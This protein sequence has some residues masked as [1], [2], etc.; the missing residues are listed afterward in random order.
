M[1]YFICLKAS[2]QSDLMQHN[3][4]AAIFHL[5]QYSVCSSHQ[6]CWRA[7]AKHKNMRYARQHLV[8]SARL[9]RFGEM[10]LW[11]KSLVCYFGALICICGARRRQFHSCRRQFSCAAIFFTCAAVFYACATTDCS[12]KFWSFLLCEIICPNG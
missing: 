11:R 3:V 2:N 5:V 12:S 6:R 1:S 9:P 7:V 8:C 10:F 4:P